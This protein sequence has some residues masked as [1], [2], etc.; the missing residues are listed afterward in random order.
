[1]SKR[2]KILSIVAADGLLWALTIAFAVHVI[3][4]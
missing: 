2:Q 1:M 3:W 4:F